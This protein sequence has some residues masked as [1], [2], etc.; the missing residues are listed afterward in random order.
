MAILKCK[1]CGGDLTVEP[2]VT[3]CECEYCGTKQTV[4]NTDDEKKLK[5]YERANRLRFRS[6][7]DKAAGV[8]ESL[9]E[10]YPEEAEAYWG[11]LLCKYGIEYVDDPA[12]GDKVPTC[13]RSSFDSFMDDP[14]FEMVMENSDA[15]SRKVYREQAKQIE[16]I[17]KG[18][19]EVS[20][21]EQPYDIFICY[22]E[23]DD[24]G[25][26]TLDS[27]LAQ[28]VYEALT[29][30]GYR[31]F[32]SRISLEDK[33]G[34]EYEP[35]IFAALNSARI[36]LAFGTS[37]DYY[38][39]VWVKNEWSRF[40]KLMAK[41]KKKY[42]IPCYKDIDAYD[43]P[44]EFA[45]LQAQD[46]GKVGAIQD[47]LRGIDK[48]N[49]GENKPATPK[50]ENIVLTGMGANGTAFLKRGYMAIEDGEWSK[51]TD[52]F[53]Q[54]LNINA[55]DGQAYWGELLAQYQCKNTDELAQKLCGELSRMI[56]TESLTIELPEWCKSISEQYI[57]WNLFNDNEANQLLRQFNYDSKVSSIK[58]II[59]TNKKHHVL[60]QSR[61]Y[62]R[63]VQ[64]ANGNVNS[65]IQQV[66][67][68]LEN[69]LLNV[70]TAA[71][72]AE[73]KAHDAAKKEADTYYERLKESL[74]AANEVAVK[75]AAFNEE[76]FTAEQLKWEEERD[77][78]P[79][80]HDQWEAAM[81]EYAAQMKDWED[82]NGEMLRNWHEAKDKY[83]SE[84]EMLEKLRLKLEDEKRQISGLFAEARVAAKGKEITAT[85]VKLQNLKP[86]KQPIYK[87][88]PKKPIE[89]VLRQ[90]PQLPL[91]KKVGK[92]EVLE[93]F[94]DHMKTTK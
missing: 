91:E 15:V 59:D 47:L 28:D 39:A 34:T 1:M 85:R 5:L 89:P 86:P 20:G 53:E 16:E 45:K 56:E 74:D 46:M 38:N 65:D 11:N 75:N 29:E 17:R 6:E 73:R 66:K 41:D 78:F 37:Y 57:F 58:N 88:S 8:Y 44:K 27:V 82:Q 63:A 7:F 70:L 40:L 42:L 55:E 4:P 77:R 72:I 14:D 35:Y 87:E 32:F 64:Y 83:A 12:T 60:E 68:K 2:D 36:M 67:E 49:G 84:K 90:E 80:E 24:D 50:A 62:Q 25:E 13:H 30:K 48:L 76:L 52:F 92:K 69:L 43:M 94:Y 71:E 23:T 81:T 54:V 18:I 31:V 21:K 9:I 51:A 3:V 93:I 22:K 61:L 19:I 33:L 79:S 10:E 26:R